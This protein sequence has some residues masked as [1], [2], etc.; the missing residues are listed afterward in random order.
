MNVSVVIPT[1]N[2]GYCILR[3]VESVIKQSVNC[4]EILV[5]DDGSTDDTADVLESYIRQHK[6][7]NKI[8]FIRTKN[9]G[10]SAARNLGVS[11]S[12]G[13][14]LA[15]LDSDDEWLS[16]KI[17]KQTDYLKKNPMKR[18]PVCKDCYQA[19]SGHRYCKKHEQ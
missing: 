1:Y 19:T 6:L 9:R 17:L 14:W 12:S 13:D 4:L 11:K 15:F 2:R 18:I 10:V 16:D 3:A 5:V 8:N 7:Q